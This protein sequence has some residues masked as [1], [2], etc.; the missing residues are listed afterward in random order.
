MPRLSQTLRFLQSPSFRQAQA[1][2]WPTG[3]VH[4]DWPN[5]TSHVKN[6]TPLFIIVSFSF[7]N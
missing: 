3:T 1:A 4:R 7:Q 6:V 5:T 2:D